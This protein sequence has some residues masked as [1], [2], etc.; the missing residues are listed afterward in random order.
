MSFASC[1]YTAFVDMLYIHSNRVLHFFRFSSSSIK[2]CVLSNS[3]ILDAVGHHIPA[4]SEEDVKFSSKKIELQSESTFQDT[5]SITHC[6][7]TENVP[8]ENSTMC[9]E[10]GNTIENPGSFDVA[11]CGEMQSKIMSGDEETSSSENNVRNCAEG[12]DVD[13]SVVESSAVCSDTL[14]EKEYER[15]E[16]ESMFYEAQ[17]SNPTCV[18]IGN[19]SLCPVTD[20]TKALCEGKD[21]ELA[22]NESGT[23]SLCTKLERSAECN[24][25]L[26][27]QIC[28]TSIIQEAEVASSAMKSEGHETIDL[29]IEIEKCGMPSVKG[30]VL[31]SK[32]LGI[33]VVHT[34]RGEKVYCIEP[35]KFGQCSETLEKRH[36]LDLKSKTGNI[37][38]GMTEREANESSR[39]SAEDSELGDKFKGE[40]GTTTNLEPSM[41]EMTDSFI[42]KV[43]DDHVKQSLKSNRYNKGNESDDKMLETLSDDGKSKD[44]KIQLEQYDRVSTEGV[45]VIESPIFKKFTNQEN[46]PDKIKVQVMKSN[47]EVKANVVLTNKNKNQSTGVG[48]TKL[49]KSQDVFDKTR[50]V[51]SNGNVRRGPYKMDDKV[52]EYLKKVKQM[53]KQ[54]GKL[55]KK[56]LEEQVDDAESDENQVAKRCSGNIK[57]RCNKEVF[58]IVW[59]FAEEIFK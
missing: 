13:Q 19:T 20:S 3:D 38:K 33:K 51:K 42:A 6:S 44:T 24:D 49:E 31:I 27:K 4:V 7:D 18:N 35:A 15:R 47:R 45:E 55:M 5:G 8:T 9:S 48:K 21:T 30:S 10:L 16:C 14:S 39:V 11:G 58:A 29:P 46:S 25:T 40:V 1:V 26:S 41:A 34:P 43:E 23:I 17:N 36:R 57:V 54:N 32:E 50:G 52:K 28:E 2:E 56:R 59:Y 12:I 37:C 53:K 22:Q